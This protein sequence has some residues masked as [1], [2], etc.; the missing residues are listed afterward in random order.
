MIAQST[1]GDWGLAAV[2]FG[3]CIIIVSMVLSFFR[4]YYT[5]SPQAKAK[6][7]SIKNRGF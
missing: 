6:A 5:E 3:G 7:E 1:I 4:W 2:I